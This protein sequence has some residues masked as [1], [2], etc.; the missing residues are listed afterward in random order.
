MYLLPAPISIFHACLA[1]TFFALTVCLAFFTSAEWIAGGGRVR[2][3]SNVSSLVELK[4]S[5]FM[6]IALVY[7]QL[8]LGATLRHTT[9]HLVV[10]SHIV[11]GFLVLIQAIIIINRTSKIVDT[12]KLIYPALLL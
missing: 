12:E 8:V 4:E 6:M 3:L 5:L 11:G 2:Q 9:N 10:I 1:Q 7:A